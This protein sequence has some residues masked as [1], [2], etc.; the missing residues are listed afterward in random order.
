MGHEVCFTHGARSSNSNGPVVVSSNISLK[1]DQRVVPSNLHSQARTQHSSTK[2]DPK[3]K[4]QPKSELSAE[5]SAK[6]L[7][8]RADAVCFDVDST[9]CEDEAIDELA[10]YLGKGREVAACTQQAMGGSMTFRQALAL[11]LNM[12]RP[13]REQLQKYVKTHPVH[14]TPG[15]AQLI[16][17]LHKRNVDVYLVSGGFRSIIKP[18]AKMLNI[19][20][21]QNVFAN[22]ILFDAQGNYAGFN[23]KEPTSD[24][25][26]KTVGKAGVCGLLKAKKS[27]KSLI[28]IG[29]GATDAEACPPADAF[30]GFG[31]NQVRETVQKLA[32]WYVYD[33]ETLLKE[34]NSSEN[35]A[36]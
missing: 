19:D 11:R 34:L 25:G 6:E 13:T 32:D 21:V 4:L 15:I 20:P 5:Q 22:E 33:F 2:S 24:S 27:Y 23:E 14:L 9:V 8:R 31:G 29:D 7:W 1:P 17:E 35:E 26:S 36:I 12:M 16:A 18:V 3:S 30:I 10:H 28:M